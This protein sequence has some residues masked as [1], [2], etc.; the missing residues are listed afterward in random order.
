MLK[1]KLENRPF[2]RS[3]DFHFHF[4]N[5]KKLSCETDF[6]WRIKKNTFITVAL[7][8]ASFCRT[9]TCGQLK[10]AYCIF[11]SSIGEGEDTI[12][13]YQFQ[14]RPAKELVEGKI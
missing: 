12:S 14:G 7:H 3:K 1:E 5:E 6:H 10:N 8:L 9:E 4:E 13:M 2:S 11:P